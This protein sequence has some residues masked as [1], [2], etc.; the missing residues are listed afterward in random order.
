MIDLSRH[1]PIRYCN[2]CGKP[3]ANSYFEVDGK[4]V[5]YKCSKE[6]KEQEK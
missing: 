1:E 2:V 4:W 6:T 3:M 5:H